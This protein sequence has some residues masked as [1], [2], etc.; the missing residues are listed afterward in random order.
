MSKDP[1]V[2]LARVKPIDVK[3]DDPAGATVT[4]VT[5][6][7][8]PQAIVTDAPNPLGLAYA[9]FD[10]TVPSAVTVSAPGLTRLGLAA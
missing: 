3:V 1:E 6:A 7:A 2:L 9:V 8:P 5:V 10:P 4:A